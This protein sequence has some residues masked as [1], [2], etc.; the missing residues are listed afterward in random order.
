MQLTEMATRGSNSRSGEGSGHGS[1]SG[2][3]RNN[4][5]NG[6]H[7]NKNRSMDDYSVSEASSSH[8]PSFLLVSASTI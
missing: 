2:I 3:S 1:L 4:S 8:R 5:A 7:V 6:S